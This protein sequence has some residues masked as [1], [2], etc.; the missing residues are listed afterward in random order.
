M[1]KT[2]MNYNSSV[3]AIL[4]KLE[5]KEHIDTN[6]NLIEDLIT[7]IYN[8]CSDNKISDNQ[9]LGLHQFLNLS[10]QQYFI[11]CISEM[12]LKE[13]W[14]DTVFLAIQLSN[15]CLLNLFEYKTTQHPSKI[16]FRELKN[17]NQL[18]W[19]YKN[20]SIY[21]KQ[22]AATFYMLSNNNPRV[23]I[24]AEN[25]META[26]CDLACLCYD[27]LDTPLNTHFNSETLIDIFNKLEI[28]IA[29]TDSIE[30]FHF[31][32]NI[33]AKT[34][35]QFQI[36]L[37]GVDFPI[38]SSSYILLGE[39][40]KRLSN[41]QIE[42]TLSKRRKRA[43]NQV[44]TVMF[45]SGSTGTPKG[46]TFS[47]YNLLSKRY[48]RAAALPDVGNDE[49]LI[50]YLPLFHTFGRYFEMLGMIFWGGTY[51]FAT[52]PSSETL[53]NQ[54]PRTNPTG[55]ISI[56]LRWEQIYDVC[57]EKMS[58]PKSDKKRKEIIQEILGCKLRWGLSAAGWLDPQI[59]KF[60]Q[61]YGIDLISG[62]GMTEAT[63]GI[64]MNPPGKYVENS[65]GT[66]LPGITAKLGYN[67]ELMVSGHYIAK[68]LDDIGTDGI[69]P[70]PKNDDSDYWLPTGDIFKILPGDY[71]QIIDRVKDIYKNNKG[72]T[73]A[74]NKIESR[75]T[76]VPGIKHTF[77]IGD[78]K[79]YNVL[80][81]IPD[82]SDSIFQEPS[83][84]ANPR[85]YYR[86]IVTAANQDL[87]PYERVINF[88]VS[89]RD[90]SLDLGELTPKGSFNRKIIT[91]NFSDLINELYKIN[92]IELNIDNLKITI[93][94]WFYRDIGILEDDIVVENDGLFNQRHKKKLHISSTGEDG[95]IKIGDLEYKFNSN[96][97][98]IGLFSLQPRLWI[99][100]PELN[101][102]CPCKEGWDYPLESVSPIAQRPWVPA[103]E[104]SIENLPQLKKIRDNRLLQINQLLSCCLFSKSDLATDCLEKVNSLLG[105]TYN[106]LNEIIRLRI[107]A[108]ARHPSE[109]IRCNAYR[110]L[111]LD[112]PTSYYSSSFPAFVHSGLTFLNQESIEEIS[113]NNLE[114]NRLEALR[115]RLFLYRKQLDWTSFDAPREQFEQIFLM[116]VHFSNNHPKYYSSV[117]A[118]LASWVLHDKDLELSLFAKRCFLELVSEYDRMFDSKKEHYPEKFWKDLIIYDD[119]IRENEIRKINNIL[120]DTPFLRQSVILGYD[121]DD[122]NIEDLTSDGIWISRINLSISSG[123]YRI[124]IN[125]TSGKHFDLQL[126]IGEN[127]Q[128]MTALQSAYWLAAISGYS[129]HPRVLPRL[130]SCNPKLDA[131]S[132][133]Y[134]GDLNA[135]DKI[136][137]YASSY[138]PENPFPRQDAWKKLFIESFTVFFRAWMYSDKRVISGLVSPE[139]VVVPELDFHEGATILFLSEIQ[140]YN[141]TLS[142]IDPIIQN[143]YRKTI[144]HYPWCDKMLDYNWIFDACIEAFGIKE[145]KLFLNELKNDL[146]VNI[147]VNKSYLSLVSSLDTYL[148]KIGNEYYVP[149]PLINAVERYNQWLQTNINASYHAKGHTINELYRL[150]RIADYPFIARFYLFRYTYFKD[151]NK[152]VK[153]YFDLLLGKMFIEPDHSPIE[154]IE[155]SDL[156][157]AIEN[158]EDRI[159][160]SRIV[161]PNEQSVTKFDF[162]KISD[163]SS[164][165]LLINSHLSDKFGEAYILRTPLKPAEIGQL[166][167]LFY[168]EK[169]PKTISPQDK[170][171]VVLDFS[172]RIIGGICY[173]IFENKSALID[174]TVVISALKGRGLGTEIVE[175]FCSR[176]ASQGI[177]VVTTHFY[178]QQFYLKLG[179]TVDNRWGALVKFLK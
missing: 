137:E 77:L 87:A 69:I 91:E 85:E 11:K 120:I 51:I 164:D 146:I 172:G 17:Q 123:R 68:Y 166:Y 158:D 13:K 174:G 24:I 8:I 29:V 42:D 95:Y 44:S 135:W 6:R 147:N 66:L 168:L 107:E 106:Y 114:K 93:P 79:P 133:I 31:L 100:N 82:K 14:L 165:K 127:L 116:L 56:P 138:L 62:F 5:V 46:V 26:C 150:Y 55:F 122:F 175:E 118:E 53:F 117:R 76:G 102:F 7:D 142:L 15:Y 115:Q 98:D 171:F 49:V 110:I 23:A 4:E 2:E 92:H 45:S 39:Y 177:E 151:F 111:L 30:R 108:L 28:N 161:F 86:Q 78:G 40:C 67:S 144:A 160:F 131:R 126:A 41:S 143:F 179:F 54:F 149:L 153:K 34:N 152:E 22:I 128:D 145:A 162:L 97:I 156:Q 130:G 169:F 104:Y 57:L 47:I 99:A 63:G 103:H 48:S 112:N 178:L 170:F 70:Y 121:E 96:N 21:I 88:A 81:I 109:T 61:S 59:F 134:P 33:K 154:F 38:R 159:V 94:R 75:F 18:A 73:I 129:F 74:P 37:T 32:E 139:N 1:E 25:S 71:F 19:S 27:I 35:I 36:V 60:F 105:D 113:Q 89:D 16:L 58:N 125:T 140:I 167:R 84:K 101:S 90:F 163:T 148:E 173:K 10:S 52:N 176:M 141:N 119:D 155:L 132:M 83:I 80:F 43:L 72:Q 12:N 50:C 64:T 136:R 20:I 124:S 65:T 157:S 3:E 9:I